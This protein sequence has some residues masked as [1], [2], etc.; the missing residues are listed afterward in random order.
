M[1]SSGD[2]IER[3]SNSRYREG[4]ISY[5]EKEVIQLKLK[6]EDLVEKT[7]T[8]N[9]QMKKMN[10]DYTKRFTEIYAY[11]QKLET[12][13]YNGLRAPISTQSIARPSIDTMTGITSENASNETMEE[14]F[15]TR[16]K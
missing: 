13:Y 15:M 8:L 12:A 1:T 4:K 9:L 7:K 10:E 2:Y 14:L 11:M 6:N 5:L 16:Q 3:I